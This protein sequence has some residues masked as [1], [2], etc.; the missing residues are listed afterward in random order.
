MRISAHGLADLSSATTAGPLGSQRRSVFQVNRCS[1]RWK[2]P[3]ATDG[4]P[5]S[6]TQSKRSSRL[7]SSNRSIAPGASVRGRCF[8]ERIRMRRDQRRTGCTSVAQGG[9]E[10]VVDRDETAQ[11]DRD[12]VA[13]PPRI[14]ILDG[15]LEPRQDEQPVPPARPF[16]L[17]VDLVEVRG[18]RLGANVT[19][20]CAVDDVIRDREHVE[21]GA[22]VQVDQFAGIEHAIAPRRVRVKLREQWPPSHRPSLRQKPAQ[23]VG[24]GGADRE[25]A[26]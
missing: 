25:P 20:R 17:G 23:S 10:A 21:A 3:V 18:V 26:W 5:H 11:P 15:Q 6:A 9:F 4:R 12:R 13:G 16:S 14:G 19:I 24:P 1:G 8:R 2:S 22:A 7:K